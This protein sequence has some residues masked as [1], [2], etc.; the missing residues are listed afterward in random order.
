[1]K[2]LYD[3]W[4]RWHELQAQLLQEQMKLMRSVI[5]LAQ[6]RKDGGEAPRVDTVNS[7]SGNPVGL[8]EDTAL[9]TSTYVDPV[10]Q[11]DDSPN[12]LGLGVDRSGRQSRFER[13][14]VKAG[15]IS[16]LGDGGAP[17]SVGAMQGGALPFSGFGT[18][19]GEGI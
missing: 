18:R 17:S 16:S 15:P 12:V 9:K 14:D 19:G 8:A 3:D 2:S 7:V 11:R 5:L 6:S 1:M 13:V 4:Y 10:I